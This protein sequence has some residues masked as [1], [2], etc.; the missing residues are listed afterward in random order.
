MIAESVSVICVVI[1]IAVCF[2]IIY[3]SDRTKDISSTALREMVDQIN[4]SQAYAF[5]F[6]KNQEQNIKNMDLNI[7]NLDAKI[8]Q[9]QQKAAAQV[10]GLSNV[11]RG[12]EMNSMKMSN[13]IEIPNTISI[14]NAD[15][16]P[17]IERNYNKNA[18]DNRYGLGQFQ[19]GQLR[20]YTATGHAPATINLSLAKT[21]GG[22]DDILKVKTDRSV[23]INGSL[24]MAPKS[25]LNATQ[26]AKLI[27]LANQP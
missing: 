12:V 18:T 15:P 5:R 9:V 10:T 20:L 11:V 27:S 23:E 26:F 4:E 19:N 8:T 3:H 2:V 1:I 21:N 7:Q 25:C 24:C 22:F 13:N 16:G 6:D 17:M 14:R